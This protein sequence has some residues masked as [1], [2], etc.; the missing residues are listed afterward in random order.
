MKAITT[1]GSHCALQVLKG[2]KDEGLKTILICEK[3]RER[4]YRR[5]EFIDEFILVDSFLDVLD[6]K[7]SY[8]LEQNNAVLVPHGT[9]ISQ[10][11]SEQIES[12][13]T[14]VFGNKWILRWE[15]NRELKEKLM[16]EAKLDVPRSISNPKEINSL[17]IVKR[18][19]AAG[20][21]GY[22][23]ATNEAE[24]NNKRDKLIKE[25][26]ISC[27]EKLYIQEY[28][29]GVLAY[30]QYF[31]SP[32]K[33]ELEF[34]GV[35]KRHESDIEGLARIPAPQ[36][37]KVEDTPSFNVIA[38]SPLVL[39][40][41]LLDE[42][43]SMGERFVEASKKLVNPGMNGPFCI[44]GVYDENGNF[45]TFEFSARIVAGTNIFMNGSPYTTLMYDEPMSMGRRIA[46]E[47]KNAD[48]S[49]EIDKITT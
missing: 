33:E 20:G 15:S 14:P 26:T 19:G 25:G 21:K 49:N 1:L 42:V 47:I 5:F 48:S 4:L 23:L 10:M 30:L 12:F 27:D 37:M 46:R 9:L 40:E 16:H 35:D 24:Y 22:F 2:A 44:E 41:S 39:R 11:S 6:Q 28:A 29:S 32:L 13:K 3:K 38:N 31:Y 8:V 17:V 45:R 36:Q 18:Q 7:Y 34:F 43:Y